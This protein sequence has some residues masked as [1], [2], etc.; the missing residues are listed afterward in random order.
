MKFKRVAFHFI[1]RMNLLILKK[2]KN[3]PSTPQSML[4]IIRKQLLKNDIT[5]LGP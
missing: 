1:P 5:A 2:D 4:S 3:P